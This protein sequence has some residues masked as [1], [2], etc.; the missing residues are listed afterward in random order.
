M[1]FNTEKKTCFDCFQKNGMNKLDNFKC[2]GKNVEFLSIKVENIKQLIEFIRT[3]PNVSKLEVAAKNIEGE[4]PEEAQFSKLKSVIFLTTI[5]K[6]I[7]KIFTN[8]K[9]IS[10]GV[11]GHLELFT[12]EFIN[13]IIEF[14]QNTLTKLELIHIA[15]ARSSYESLEIPCQ[16]EE[17][18]I[19]FCFDCLIEEFCRHEKER[20]LEDSS[21]SRDKRYYIRKHQIVTFNNA[22]EIIASQKNLRRL[23]IERIV[24]D[25]D[26]L[27]SIVNTGAK[28]LRLVDTALRFDI[29][30]DRAKEFI[31]R[32]Q[33]IFM[34]RL[35]NKPGLRLI[36]ENLR[37]VEILGINFIQNYTMNP[38]KEKNVLSKLKALRMNENYLITEILS[39]LQFSEELEEIACVITYNEQ[40]TEI[41][42]TS[43]NIKRFFMEFS[44]LDVIKQVLEQFSAL[45]ILEARLWC[46]ELEIIIAILD[47]FINLK[48]V[49]I[50]IHNNYCDEE[51]QQQV[52]NYLK[53]EFVMTVNN[54]IKLFEIKNNKDFHLTVDWKK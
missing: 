23:A 15:L 7:W 8:L 42:R 36:L 52:R 47:H 12:S 32:L 48:K 9:A 6:N 51:D 34:T 27:E 24:I 35:P 45:E 38:L 40:V 43:P 54:D 10:F 39:S 26:F 5:P 37:D 18:D 41:S 33:S 1:E 16:L 4:L 50:F 2:S 17:L 44:R 28:S 21:R 49:H 11:K 22:K 20:M 46:F 14:N 53:P 25:E 3:F 30:S 31:G 29:V 19:L 13:G